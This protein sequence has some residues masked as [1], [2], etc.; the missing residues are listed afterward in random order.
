MAYMN[1]TRATQLTVA[2]RFGNALTAVKAAYQRR[3][4]YDQTVRELNDLSD[5]D[6]ND[7]GIHRSTITEVAM[8]AAYGK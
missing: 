3:R 6:L 1:S 2:D 5:R 7:L 8:Q 4:I